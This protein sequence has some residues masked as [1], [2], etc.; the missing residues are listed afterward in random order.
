MYY[1]LKYLIK[2]IN[3]KLNYEM[4]LGTIYRR[5]KIACYNVH[6]LPLL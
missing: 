5:V 4:T 3:H 1:F 6:N 2:I